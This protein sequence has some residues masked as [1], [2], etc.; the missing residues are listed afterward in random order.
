VNWVRKMMSPFD[1]NDSLRRMGGDA[2]LFQEMV[3]FLRADTP[4]R[5]GELKAALAINDHAAAAR[6]A[7]SL[8]GFAL[9]FGARRA[10][11]AAGALE[12]CATLSS[13]DQKEA[14]EEL[15]SAMQ[16]LIEAIATVGARGDSG[17]TLPVSSAVPARIY[18]TSPRP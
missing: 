6:A 3:G 15:E 16:E 14:L 18:G 4:V 12:R 7:H 9:N 17:C 1:Y 5:L 13:A 8:K 11:M 2:Q 10:A